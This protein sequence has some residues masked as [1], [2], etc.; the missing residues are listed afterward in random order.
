MRLY[1]YYYII[2]IIIYYYYTTTNNKQQ[3]IHINDNAQKIYTVLT[4]FEENPLLVMY[5]QTIDMSGQNSEDTYLISFLRHVNKYVNTVCKQSINIIKRKELLK[6]GYHVHKLGQLKYMPPISRIELCRS[7]KKD[8]TDK[9]DENLSCIDMRKLLR[10]QMNQILSMLIDIF[11]I[12]NIEI[13]KVIS[14]ENFLDKFYF[15]LDLIRSCNDESKNMPPS[16]SFPIYYIYSL[17][18]IKYCISF[19]S[20]YLQEHHKN[21]KLSNNITTETSTVIN[22]YIN[23]IVTL[24]NAL[25][26]KYEYILSNETEEEQFDNAIFS[27]NLNNPVAS[28]NLQQAELKD[29]LHNKFQRFHATKGKERHEQHRMRDIVEDGQKLLLFQEEGVSFVT[30]DDAINDIET[31]NYASSDSIRFPAEFLNDVSASTIYN[32]N[33]ELFEKLNKTFI[34]NFSSSSKQRNKEL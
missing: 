30:N 22:C 28:L 15:T 18:R 25:K 26:I 7:F 27:I 21:I 12:Y 5:Q 8:P 32:E 4:H 14:D 17:N 20:N 34:E 16:P 11:I 24:S 2:I 19:M 23:T 10:D 1:Q 6:R 3:H 29:V 31:K 9:Y 33:V 13:S